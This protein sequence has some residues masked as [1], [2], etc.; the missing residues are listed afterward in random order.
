MVIKRRNDSIY[1]IPVFT[2]LH[3]RI[4]GPNIQIFYEYD[5]TCK[6]PYFSSSST[7]SAF[8]FT[9]TTVYDYFLCNNLTTWEVRLELE[10]ERWSVIKIMFIKMLIPTFNTTTFFK[11]SRFFLSTCYFYGIKELL[12]FS[13]FPNFSHS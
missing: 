1:D 6:M 13:T 11:F 7:F 3:H 12:P 10:V 4:P 2:F 9:V 5:F 8:N